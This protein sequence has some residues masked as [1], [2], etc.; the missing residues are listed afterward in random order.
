MAES[1]TD[2]S[3]KT[4]EP[5]AKR[6]EESRK[7]GQVAMSREVNNWVILFA[8]TMVIGA[9]GGHMFKELSNLMESFLENAHQIPTGQGGVA[10]ALKV[11][12]F[13]TMLILA[14]P[15]MFLIIA[16][17]AAPFLQVGPL[18]APESIKPD[19]SKISPKKGFGRLF[20]M[21][22]LMEFA[23]GLLKLGVIGT[24]GTLVLMPYFD[25]IDH[26]VGLPMIALLAEIQTLVI[27]LMIAVLVVLMIIAVID[28]VYQ[29]A[30]H[31][32]KMRMSRKEIRDE[33]KQTEGD[34]MVRAKLR[35]L[36]S[37]KAR[38]RMMQSVP[39]ADVVITNPT[40]F[41]I[42]L[43]YDPETMD[44]PKCVAKGVDETALRIRE[45][46]TEH[47]IILFENRPLAR[48]LYEVV[49]V[50]ETIPPDHFKAVAE[51]ISYVFKQRGTK[52]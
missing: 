12:I 51:V 3:Q 18:Y 27:R 21:R 45:L 9:L 28:L 49:E 36:R 47:G 5:T 8:A 16:A 17:I 35:Q 15:V 6:L 33:Y 14:F 40:H 23:K 37:E 2:D 19:W 24:V 32:K 38:Q 52:N 34:P 29:R 46:A 25:N 4:E 30:E 11:G 41:S 22:S 20:S 48:T 13:Q 10:M 39:S 42:A 43:K 44:A 7:K 50:D 31:M 26:I 1:E